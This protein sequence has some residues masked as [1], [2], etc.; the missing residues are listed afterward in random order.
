MKKYILIALICPLL[1]F[2]QANKLLRQGLKSTNFNEQIELFTKVIELEPNNLDAFFYRALA[3]YNLQ[4]YTSAILDYTTVIFYNPDADS[5]YNR[6][7]SKFAL[8]DYLGAKQDYTK[9]LELN[10]D[11]IDATYNLGLTKVYLGEFNEAI[12]DFNKITN[13]F[14]GDANIYLQKAI[15]YMELKNYKEAFNNF[16]T[17]IL[18]NPNSNAFYMRGIAL[19][20][21]NY[22]KEAK[23]DFYKAIELDKNNM[24]CY[25]YLGVAQLFL[26][27]FAPA[28]TTFN[29]SIKFDALDFDAYLGLAIAQYKA[30]DKSQAKTNFQKAKNLINPNGFN[31]Y[32]I[33]AFSDTYWVKNQ[34]FYFNEVFKELDAL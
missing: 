17:S 3:K 9:A 33:E 11:L 27:E 6:A 28:V 19:L 5:Y 32:T 2:G 15:A 8:Q 20:R 1:S 26:G 25:F 10:K 31:S 16:G 24:P 30:N 22:Y 21:I 7:N 29:E 12:I 23:A 34:S 18:L 14:P 13:K 4:D